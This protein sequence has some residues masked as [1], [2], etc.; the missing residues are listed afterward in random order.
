MSEPK[1]SFILRQHTPMIHFQH[2]QVG[3]TVRPSELK[4]KLDRFIIGKLTDCYAADDKTRLKAFKEHE[5]AGWLKRKGKAEHPA[6]DYQVKATVLEE[7]DGVGPYELIPQRY[8]GFFANM[9]RGNDKYFCFHKFVAVEFSSRQQELAGYIR[10][11]FPAFLMHTNFGTRQSKGF[12][13]YYLAQAH[14]QFL[15]DAPRFAFEVDTSRQREEM[16]KVK[17][18]FRIIDLFYRSL[19]SGI[20]NSKMDGFYFKSMLWW[21]LKQQGLQWDKKTIKQEF[22]AGRENGEKQNR[23]NARDKD[24][25]LFYDKGEKQLIKNPSGEEEESHLLWRDLLGL[26]S[27]QSWYAYGKDTIKKDHLKGEVKRF[28][29]PIFFK[30][31]RTGPDSFRVYFDVPLPLRQ[32]FRGERSDVADAELLE[33]WFAI[34]SANLNQAFSIPFPARFDFD[35]FFRVAFNTSLDSHVY[36]GNRGKG[37]DF[38]DLKTIY[39]SLKAQVN[40]A[41]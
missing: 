4:S 17:E 9:G 21:Y 33:E 30:P 24:T 31:L 23:Q 32:A 25:P 40:N 3:A 6:L 41:R 7:L 18:L 14:E 5:R 28:K 22:Y 15:A 39:D 10:K 16:D 20:N 29:S 2:R 11:H 35:D 8:P 34:T 38:R 13:S 37:Y 12:G 26:S 1:L 19:R 36:P 27:E